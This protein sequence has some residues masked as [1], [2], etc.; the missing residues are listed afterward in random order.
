MISLSTHPPPMV[1]TVLPSSRISIFVPTPR[2]AEPFLEMIVASTL[3]PGFAGSV[4]AASSS[5]EYPPPRSLLFLICMISAIMETAIY[6]GVSALIF[7]PMGV[8]TL[9]RAS[10]STPFSA[11]CS[12][13]IATLRLLPIIPT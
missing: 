2:G 10:R 13:T 9:S 1:S 5:L 11:S 6:S 3:F 8:W 7:S 12:F 4:R